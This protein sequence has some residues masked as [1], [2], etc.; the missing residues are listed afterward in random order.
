M[1]LQQV[2]LKELVFCRGYVHVIVSVWP[3]PILID[4][5]TNPFI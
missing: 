2:K 3:S 4:P 5:V 1:L